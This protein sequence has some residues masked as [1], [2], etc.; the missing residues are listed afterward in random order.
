M[1]FAPRAVECRRGNRFSARAERD[2]C[3]YRIRRRE[4]R[5]TSPGRRIERSSRGWRSLG[6]AGEDERPP[7]ARRQIADGARGKRRSLEIPCYPNDLNIGISSKGKHQR[8]VIVAGTGGTRGRFNGRASVGGNRRL[9]RRSRDIGQLA[10]L[11]A[12]DVPHRGLMP[13]HREL[14]EP[15]RGDQQR[16]EQPS[17]PSPLR[18]LGEAAIVRVPDHFG[19]QLN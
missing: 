2:R 10:V 8:T 7:W 3:R 1:K 17:P 4:P 15:Q 6:R 14:R 13:R 16:R 19:L 11:G 18:E 12:P 5:A 9:G